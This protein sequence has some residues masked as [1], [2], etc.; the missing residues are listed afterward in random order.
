MSQLHQGSQGFFRQFQADSE[1]PLENRVFSIE[2]EQARRQRGNESDTTQEARNGDF[3][4]PLDFS[5]SMNC[6]SSGLATSGSRSTWNLPTNSGIGSGPRR[7]CPLLLSG[8]ELIGPS[9]KLRATSTDSGP[10]ATRTILPG[11]STCVATMNT[12][13]HCQMTESAYH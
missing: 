6:F 3:Q 4:S 9:A 12:D 11:R 8:T 5:I 7:R 13:Y 2:V 10:P 1:L